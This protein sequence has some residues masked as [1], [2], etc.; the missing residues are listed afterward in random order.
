MTEILD[1][2]SQ[3]VPDALGMSLE[4]N[5]EQRPAPGLVG[6]RTAS[7][8][9]PNAPAA[10]AGATHVLALRP[11]QADPT[12]SMARSGN[13]IVGSTA[14]YA[15][16]IGNNGPASISAAN[17]TVTDTLPAGL[18]YTSRTGT[19]WTCGA[20]GQVVTCTYS[21]A[22]LVSGGTLPVLTL[23]VNVV[24]GALWTNTAT[25][26]S[27]A[28]GDNDITNSTATDTWPTNTTTLA[29]GTDPAASTIAPSALATDVNQ[30]TLRTNN[31]TE[32][33]SSVTVNLSSSTGIDTLAI[34]DSLNNVLGSVAF[35]A[36]GGPI[37]IPVIGMTATTTLQ[38]FKVRVTPLVHVSMPAP[39][40]ATYTITAPVTAWAG[41]AGHAGSDTNPNALT[42]D[43]LS[44][45]SATATS[46]TRSGSKINLNWTTSSSSD[47]STTSG[48]VVYR[49][50][51]SSAGS[52]VPIE[53]SSPLKGEANGT[54]T[55]ACVVSSSASTALTLTDGPGGSS[56]C[57]NSPLS[58]TQAFTYKVFQKD[59][60]GNFDAGVLISTS[61]GSTTPG[62]FNAFETSTAA[63]SV[64]GAIRTKIAG[65]AFSLALVARDT[66]GTAV[67][68]SFS[69]DVAVNLIANTSTGVAL[70]GGCPVSGTT[71]SVGMQA[72]SAGRSTVSFPAVANSWRDVRVRIRYPASAPTITSCSNDN[73]AVKPASLSA[74]ASDGDWETAG[75]TQTLNAATTTATP[76]HKAGRPFTLR[77]TG[78]NSTGTVTG[79]YAGS[80]TSSSACILPASGCTLGSLSTGT[81]SSSGG[82]AT[83]TDASYSEVGAI[84]TSFVDSSYASVNSAD[85]AADCSGYHVCSGTIMIGRFVP[86]HFEISSPE[87]TNSCTS[88]A[89]PFTYF[90]QDGFTTVFTITAQ[91]AANDPTLNY[92]SASSLAKLPLT[93]WSD[94]GFAVSTWSLSQPSGAS[95]A[96]SSTGPTA[97]NSNT[98]VSGTTTVTA[99]HKIVSPTSPA[100][101]TTVMV[102]VLPVDADSVTMPS[103]ATLGAAL[104]RSGRLHLA[105][106]YGSISPLYMPVE[107]QYWSGKSWV[108]NTDD[109][110][111]TTAGG[112]PQVTF[113]TITDWTLTPNAFASGEMSLGGLKIEKGTPG[114]TTISA[115]APDWLKPDPSAQATI[116]IYGTKESRKAIHIRELY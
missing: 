81:F 55:V 7:F 22:S 112:T 36:T 94:Y 53:G 5:N 92:T 80:P 51:S 78:Y 65:T 100:K 88:G 67:L 61:G 9:T 42:I 44:P 25:V 18:T 95:L 62:S 59:T 50:A 72:I 14:S 102:T 46:A 56:S 116:G 30:F 82:T 15:L 84:S 76:I 79:N 29:T 89:V 104:L 40:G 37:T 86:D 108:K 87:V 74:V 60:R 41:P 93:A 101:Q 20:A 12:I 45:N 1:W 97:T 113:P 26:S 106:A 96:A 63:G 2:A 109:S 32:P 110:C 54:A 64:T 68:S 75:T 49:W 90:G 69:D 10:D 3:A 98:W 31:S 111:T 77:V 23:N 66:A 83:S 35:P 6:T 38:T 85:T 114:T 28:D 39:P 4:I 105:N 24:S 91:N 57:T 58:P 115:T 43:N 34:T 71:L 70:S 8:S 27:G 13:L 21:G 11:I 103:A 17:I 48:S 73:F 19:G 16:T 99:K 47:F 107:A 33:I 52:E